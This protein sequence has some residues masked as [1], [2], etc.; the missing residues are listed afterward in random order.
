M[1]EHLE[2]EV[3]DA[4]FLAAED[5]E[6]FAM[7]RRVGFGAS[8]S[9]ILLGV[10]PFPDGKIETLIQQKLATSVTD[11]ELA[12]GKMVNVRKGSDLE[13]LIMK[14]FEEA[15]GIDEGL[16]VKPKAMYRIPDTPLTVNF[17]G[18]LTLHEHEIPVECKFASIYGH[19]YYD[20]SKSVA[21]PEKGQVKGLPMPR[22][23]IPEGDEPVTAKY[24]LRKA[25][26]AGI[27]VYYYTQVQQQLLASRAPFAYLT[28]LCDKDWT[29]RTFTVL[30][31]HAVQ[32]KLRRVAEDAW[33]KVK[34]SY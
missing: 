12:I 11:K 14:K 19:R 16:L 27:P 6:A 26:E 7:I 2:V 33:E 29:L 10:N 4:S 32:E 5:Q 25:K 23:P 24:I 28:A 18:V 15:F 13:P 22:D 8:D 17:D 34:N 9:S 20:L 3:E 1:L 30:A 31:D 21:E